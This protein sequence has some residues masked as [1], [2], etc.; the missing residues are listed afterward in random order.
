MTRGWISSFTVCVVFRVSILEVGVGLSRIL[1][2]P[3]VIN[4]EYKMGVW[5]VEVDADTYKE[6]QAVQD[7][8]AI[9]ESTYENPAH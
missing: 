5:R 4:A 3:W 1:G 8:I 6:A 7:I 9:L 2:K